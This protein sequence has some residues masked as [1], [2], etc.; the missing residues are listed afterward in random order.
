VR[1]EVVA[2]QQRD[3][4]LGRREQPRLTVV[5]EVALVDRLQPERVRLRGERRED[6]LVL[7]VAAQRGAPDRALAGGLARDRLPEISL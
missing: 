7:R 5:E 6:G 1:V 3:V 4:V 2:E